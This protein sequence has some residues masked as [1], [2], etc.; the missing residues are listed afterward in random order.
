MIR[1]ALVMSRP[2]EQAVL[3]QKARIACKV[4]HETGVSVS[5]MK[6]P[7]RKADIVRARW[8][9]MYAM[10]Q[11]GHSYPAIGQYFNRDHTTV[12]HALRSMGA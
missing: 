11:A 7:T 8:A 5:A 6:S 10:R 4:A 3:R 9:A 1:E 12:I 2:T